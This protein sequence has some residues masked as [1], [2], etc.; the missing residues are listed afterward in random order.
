MSDVAPSILLACLCLLVD[1][2]PIAAQPDVLWNIGDRGLFDRTDKAY[3]I[4][5]GRVRVD[6]DGHVS[7]CPTGLGPIASGRE[8]VKEIHLRFRSGHS[9]DYWLHIGWQP[10]GQGEEQFEVLSNAAS[11][12][13]SRM[14]DGARQPYQRID[15]RFRIKV[16]AGEN[17][18]KL[19]HLSGDGLHFV[20][21]V[22]AK[23]QNPPPP[24][25]PNLKFPTLKAY[26]AEIGEPGVVLD[27]TYVRLFAPRRMDQAAK[28]IFPYLVKSYDELY[29]LVGVHTEY[30]IVVYH[31]PEGSPHAWGGTSV[32]TIWYSYKNLDLESSKEWQ[33]YR[34]PHVSGYIEEMAHNFVAATHAQFGWEMVGWSIG[35]KVAQGVADNPIFRKHLVDT[36]KG[37][38]QTFARYVKSGYV[39]PEDIPANV[40]DRIHAY[41]LWRAEEKYGADFWPDFFREV[42]KKRSALIGVTHDKPDERRNERYRITV[43]C[44]DQLV[45]L[46]F[47]RVL[48]S[49][50]ISV[51]TDTKSL[52]PTDPGW[53]RRLVPKLQ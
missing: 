47:K 4:Q 41:L 10:G 35:A 51:T 26:E 30:K 50:Q 7:G 43:D 42:R 6:T 14:V 29:R 34:V 39:F 12:G 9:G 25:K 23:S 32:C 52:H 37:Q 5:S 19:R 45:G 16:K 1:G 40:C 8:R 2:E 53:D 49:A 33:R 20:N 15:E 36:R 46:N 28:V 31:F 13:E 44:F 17:E 48:E 3:S 24:L 27:S 22:L 21:L 18:I 11:V 38:A